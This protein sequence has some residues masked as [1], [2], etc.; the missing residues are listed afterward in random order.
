MRLVTFNVQRFHCGVKM[1][2]H[3]L[4]DLGATVAALQEVMQ[5]LPSTLSLTYRVMLRPMHSFILG[6]CGVV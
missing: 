3:A 4:R 2:A 5:P 1:V 6:W